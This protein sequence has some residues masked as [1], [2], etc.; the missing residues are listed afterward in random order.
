[1][2]STTG[3]VKSSQD[4]RTTNTMP[5]FCMSQ[6]RV[7]SRH[8][9]SPEITCGLAP[10][11]RRLGLSRNELIQTAWNPG[12]SSTNPDR[13]SLNSSTGTLAKEDSTGCLAKRTHKV[14]VDNHDGSGIGSANKA[15]G[16]PVNLHRRSR[17]PKGRRLMLSQWKTCR[18]PLSATRRTGRNPALLHRRL[19]PLRSLPCLFVW[20]TKSYDTK[21]MRSLRA[22][23]GGN[24][25]PHVGH[26]LAASGIFF[27]PH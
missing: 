11:K 4:K 2:N 5:K 19:P 18:S 26:F 21:G 7:S 23:L 22:F 10:M 15:S 27:V 9:F 17:R 12:S 24:M 1:M 6:R 16:L 25:R 8:T 13:S 3:S 20:R 14:L